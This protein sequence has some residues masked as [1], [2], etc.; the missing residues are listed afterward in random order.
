MNKE[1]KIPGLTEMTSK[2]NTFQKE[3]MNRLTE[4]MHLV[5]GEKSP[6]TLFCPGK[7]E[8]NSMSGGFSEFLNTTESM[9]NDMIEIS[10]IMMPGVTGDGKN[11]YAQFTENMP[12][13]QARI[14]KKYLEI[15]QSG[16]KGEHKE[17]VNGVLAQLALY[18]AAVIELLARAIML[19]DQGTQKTMNQ[20]IKES[21]LGDEDG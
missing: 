18:N 11:L 17:K 14:M 6:V 4:A 16:I 5:F 19:V 1:F 21:W 13:N 3:N 8:V 20:L 9:L 12:E 2:I 15:L 7:T 10:A